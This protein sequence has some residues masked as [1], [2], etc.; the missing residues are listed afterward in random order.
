MPGRMFIGLGAVFIIVL[1]AFYD[2]NMDIVKGETYGE[3]SGDRT[4][5]F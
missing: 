2:Y 3:N 4:S 1:L 5:G